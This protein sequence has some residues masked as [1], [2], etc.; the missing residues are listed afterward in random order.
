MIKGQDDYLFR[1]NNFYRL[2]LNN[3]QLGSG[4]S[5]F[6][7]YFPITL[8]RED[9]NE[10]VDQPEIYSGCDANQKASYSFINVLI[11]YQKVGLSPTLKQA[12]NQKLTY[13]NMFLYNYK[14]N[15]LSLP[16]SLYTLTDDIGWISSSFQKSFDFD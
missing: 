6:D 5:G 12:L 7:N 11:W 10:L 13:K 1:A 15:S 8:D 4:V 3:F 16:L 14:F 9:C 2:G